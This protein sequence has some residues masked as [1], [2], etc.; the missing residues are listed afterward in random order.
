MRSRHLSFLAVPVLM[1]GAVAGCSDTPKSPDTVDSVRR[2]LEQSGFKDVSVSQDRDKGVITLTGT[3]PTE[4]DKSQAEALAKANAGPMVV[5]DEIAVRPPGNE[6]VA[7]TVDS[8]LDKSIEKQMHAELAKNKL[9]D[10]KYDVKNGVITLTGTVNSQNR[11]AY[12]EK[13]ASDVPHVKQ[14]VNEIEI[15]NPKATSTKS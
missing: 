4:S 6:S 15:K 1:M 7:K 12:V 8:D 2:S 3:V 9:S 13:L 11:K 10:V 14:V 5:A